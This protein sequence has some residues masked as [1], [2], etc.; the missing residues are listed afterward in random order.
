ML[1]GD[2]NQITWE[3]FNESFYAKFFSDNL[4]Y[5][6]Q[7]E[8]EPRARRCDCGAIQCR[9]IVAAGKTLKELPACRSCRRSH[10]GRCSAGSE[11]CYKCKQP[12]HE[13]EQA[14]TVVTSTLPILGHF[15]F[16]LFDF[17]SSH[18]F[19]SSMF[20]Q[21]MCLE[22]E[23]LNNILS[24]STPSGEVMLSK[25]K[26]KACEIEIA[27]HLLDVT[28]IVLDRRDFDAILGM[29][30]L[31]AK[32]ANI[33]CSCKEVVFNPPSSTSLKYKGTGTVVLPKVISAMKAKNIP[34]FFLMSFQDLPPRKI[35]FAFKLELDT[36]PVSRAPYKMAPTE[37]KELKVKLQ[38]LLDKGFI[39]P[40]VSSWGAPIALI[41]EC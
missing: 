29:Y 33:D 22:V 35:D 9:E 8:S 39:R 13:V 16:V 4:R 31:P 5:T 19:I 10:G 1:G 20:V 15:A 2:V 34:T 41:I 32:Y 27:N 21:H 12:G 14:G 3:Q 23:P 40:S 38:E 25:E 24:V 7:Q 18:S 30:W 37:L 26:I 17:R 36:V 28:L 6:K 11:V